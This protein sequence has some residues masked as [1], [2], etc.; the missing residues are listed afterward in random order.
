M[1]ALT[2]TELGGPVVAVCGLT[3]GAGTTTLACLLARGAAPASRAPVLLAELPSAS[4][5]ISP[6]LGLASTGSIWRRIASGAR[7]APAPGPDG[8]RVLASDAEAP[9][10]ASADDLATTL[11]EL[12]RD[13]GLV[14][15]DCGVLHAPDARAAV[16][17]ATH[18]VWAMPTGHTAAVRAASLLGARGLAPPPGGRREVLAVVATRSTAL[19]P[20]ADRIVR[21]IAADRC[22]RLVLVPHARE[23]AGGRLRSEPPRISASLSAIGG[24]VRLPAPAEASFPTSVDHPTAGVL[25]PLPGEQ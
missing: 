23:L 16:A 6:V 4:G 14:V 3:G 20:R 15:L 24:V 2:F 12:R 22:D 1:N 11:A 9:E 5:G 21:E 8:L 19:P 13:H 25:S 7:P 10:D 17:T 18:V